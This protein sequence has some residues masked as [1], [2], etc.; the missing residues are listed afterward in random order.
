MGFKGYLLHGHA[1]PEKSKWTVDSFVYNGG[2]LNLYIVNIYLLSLFY[3]LLLLI[4]K[5]CLTCLI[6]NLVFF[7]PRSLNFFL[8]APLHNHCPLVD[9]KDIY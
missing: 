9:C 5:M 7:P 6:V 3:I 2:R 1:D 8:I 4:N